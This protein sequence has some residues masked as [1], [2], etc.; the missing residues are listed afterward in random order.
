VWFLVWLK[1]VERV[2]KMER[3]RRQVIRSEPPT[4]DRKLADKIYEDIL[5]MILNGEFSVGSKLPTEHVLSDQLNVSRPVLRQSLKQ[6][7]VDGLIV[8]RQ[9]SGSYVKRRPIGAVLD[10]APA[11][12]IADIQ[13]NFEFR[14][15]VEGEAALLAAQRRSQDDLAT[16]RRLLNDLDKCI[17]NEELGVDADE[18]FH[19][20][21]CAASGNQ[22]FGFARTSM[23]AN[24]MTGLN[25]TRSLSLAKSRDRL[26]QV[27]QLVQQEHYEILNAIEAQNGEAARDAMRTHI[28]NAKTR[29]FEG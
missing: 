11:G 22:Y 14:A 25:L 16:L 13:R 3:A 17:E 2:Y 15:A 9:G 12:S 21:I 6:L 26:D 29:V 10:L 28:E 19:A 18:A 23:R 20:A 7:K 4:G 5:E 24:I 1:E 8:S 27:Q